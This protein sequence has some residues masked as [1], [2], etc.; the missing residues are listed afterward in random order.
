[1]EIPC[2]PRQ[3]SPRCKLANRSMTATPNA[4][5]DAI[6]VDIDRPIPAIVDA[7]VTDLTSRPAKMVAQ[8]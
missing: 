8:I 5:E 1:M 3:T 6:V 4:G 2:T 7:I